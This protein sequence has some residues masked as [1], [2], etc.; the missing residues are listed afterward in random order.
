[1]HQLPA[2]V[3][4]HRESVL[5]KVLGHLPDE[6]LSAL[7]LGLERHAG[8]L[9]AGQLYDD[10]DGGGCAVGVMLRELTPSA[11]RTGRLRFQVRRHRHRS[12]LTERTDFDDRLITR[13]SHVE[14]CFDRTAVSLSEHTGDPDLPAAANATGRWMAEA[15]RRRLRTRNRGF[16]V[17]SGW[18]PG[19][20][21]PR[22]ARVLAG[23]SALDR[24]RWS[25]DRGG[26]PESGLAR[27]RA[28]GV[29]GS[30]VLRVPVWRVPWRPRV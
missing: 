18:G 20:V 3:A 1:V 13:L 19:P 15:C 27:G 4:R 2:T 21:S 28:P 30:K 5:D 24:L 25:C 12:V 11:Y 9:I 17:P 7:A 8:R 6:L 26:G 16:F 23:N 10:Y 29:A 22:P 14:M